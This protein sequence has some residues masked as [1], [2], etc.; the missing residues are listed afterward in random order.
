[1]REVEQP[2]TTKVQTD[3]RSAGTIQHE[4]SESD[5]LSNQKNTAFCFIVL[6]N[7]ITLHHLEFQQDNSLKTK[8]NTCIPA[9]NLYT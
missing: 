4:H 5:G 3:P 8:Y 9:L 1:M 6:L 2:G 7:C